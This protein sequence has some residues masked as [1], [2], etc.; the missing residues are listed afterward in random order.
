M[1][2]CSICCTRQVFQVECK[3]D[4][5]K[6]ED[7]SESVLAE[8]VFQFDTILYKIVPMFY[9]YHRFLFLWPEQCSSHLSLYP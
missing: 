7:D 8:Q 3:S 9:Y 1:T 5:S 4:D 2:N 6:D